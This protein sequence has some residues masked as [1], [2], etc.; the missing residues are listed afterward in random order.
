MKPMTKVLLGAASA[1]ALGATSASA[2]IVCNNDGDC[3]HVKNH[4]DYKPELHLRVHPD[5]W[6][7]R[8]SDASHYRWHEHNGHGFW[9]GGVWVDL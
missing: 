5:N 6:K 2:A 7:W 1:L 4:Y 8:E 3:W 9:R